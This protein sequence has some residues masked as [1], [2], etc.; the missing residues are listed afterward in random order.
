M[1]HASRAGVAGAPRGFGKR[2]QRLAAVGVSTVAASLTSMRSD[3][4]V[5]MK[6]KRKPEHVATHRAIER[7]KRRSR[8]RIHRTHAAGCGNGQGR[9]HTQV[10]S[11]NRSIIHYMVTFLHAI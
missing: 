3:A 4:C 10:R 6:G 7:D 11:T 9:E 5:I 2:E 1:R 8:R